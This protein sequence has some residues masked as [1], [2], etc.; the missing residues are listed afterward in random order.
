[1]HS[2]H[3]I[4]S[5]MTL[6]DLE[7]RVSWYEFQAIHLAQLRHEQLPS[8]PASF[9]TGV[10]QPMQGQ[11]QGQGHVQGGLAILTTT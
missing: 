10:P 4:R 9:A 7:M 6:S 2:A 11:G 1:M 5:L 3:V 8:E